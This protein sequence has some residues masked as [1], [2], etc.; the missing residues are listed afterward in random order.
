V[1][2]G[3]HS[4]VVVLGELS[5]GRPD[6]SAASASASASR[7]DDVEVERVRAE[8]AAAKKA[9]KAAQSK[10]DP[11]VVAFVRELC[12]RWQEHVTRH[13]ELLENK[14]RS[15]YEVGRLLEDAGGGEDRHEERPGVRV[16]GAEGT[17]ESGRVGP[18][19][20]QLKAA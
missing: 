9:L 8:K 7:D 5:Q 3:Q 19:V 17:E 12:D 14:Q 2:D 6:A 20:R 1:G 13:P 16:V 4:H 15:R 11:E 10:N 18:E